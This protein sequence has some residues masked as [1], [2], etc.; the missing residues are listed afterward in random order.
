MLRV[1]GSAKNLCQG[2]NRRDMLRVGGLG[3]AGIGLPD[4]LRLTAA[5]ATT[6]NRQPASFGRA[7]S[8]ILIHLYG[9][10][11]QLEWAD[12]KLDAPSEIRGE[13]G[14]ISSTL[15]SVPVCELLPNM[16]KVM[17]RTTVIRSMNHPHPI[18]GVAYAWTGTPDIDVAME[19]SPYDARH[20]PF[21]SS[22]VDYVET[23][24]NETRR[25]ASSRQVPQ[26][27][28]LPFPFST[29]RIGEVPRAGPYAAFLG[30]HYNPVWTE[31]VGQA[32]KGR[33][34]TLTD[35]VYS[36]N[37]PYMGTAEDSYFRVPSA[38]K[39][40]DE[41]TIDRLEGRRSLVA[42]LDDAQDQLKQLS[43]SHSIDKYRQMA[44]S[45]LSSHKLRTAL[46]L[47]LESSAVRA[48]YGHTLL[49]QSCLAARRLIEAGS[50]VVS[51]F[52]DEYGLAGSG[53]DTH[54]N[55]FPRMKQELC[56]GFD[57]AWYGLITDLEQRGLLD[58]VLVVC[59]SEHGRTPKINA[60][61]GGGRD[62]WSRAYSTFVAGAG[63][64]RGNVVGATDRIGGDVIDRP[65]SPKDLLATMYHLLGIDHQMMISNTEG[66]PLPLVEGEIIQELLA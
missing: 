54:W 63:V 64:T 19:L 34:K 12:L 26:N 32:T 3:T 16:A 57:R 60:S 15:P 36:G 31:F 1:L 49:G 17:D 22:V 14:G 11:S 43:G 13:L 62:H 45:L 7:K 40:L 2:I 50:R 30:N 33:R 25:N 21:F 53:W 8:V 5:S 66:R 55:H 9:S 56:P 58:D 6:A 65:V 51:V 52:W 46:D 27:I 10:P 41:L 23:R 4:F 48:T 28:A 47:R 61:E 39:L 29:K 42:Q 37:D 38:T 59:G 20:W 44:M 35:K 18:H 24:R